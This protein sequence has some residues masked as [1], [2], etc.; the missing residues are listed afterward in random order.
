MR[1]KGKDS[2][3]Y[4]LAFQHDIWLDKAFKCSASE[5]VVGTDD[6]EVCLLEEANHIVETVVEL[7][8]SNGSCIIMHPIH[9]S[10]FDVP[11][12]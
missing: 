5:V 8:V 12:E 1:V 4:P 7:V 11:L 6:R 2:D 10:D 3:F 9:Q